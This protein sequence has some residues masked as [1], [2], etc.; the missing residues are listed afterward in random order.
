MR[1]GIWFPPDFGD[2]AEIIPAPPAPELPLIG[3]CPACGYLGYGFHPVDSR[4]W[5]LPFICHDC[6]AEIAAE[7]ASILADR[8]PPGRE[9]SSAV[10]AMPEQTRTLQKGSRGSGAAETRK[11]AG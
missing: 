11:A 5:R 1:R 10:P 3:M 4:G 7:I 6:A 2:P 8:I 9:T